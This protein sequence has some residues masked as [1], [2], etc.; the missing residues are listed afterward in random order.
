VYVVVKSVN[1]SPLGVTL[2][3]AKGAR[4]AADYVIVTVPLGVL[5]AGSIS[6]SPPLPTAKRT[7]INTMV[8]AGG[9]VNKSIKGKR[10]RDWAWL[11]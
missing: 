4:I 9:W 11:G 10:T 8:R 7:A 2:T 3:T 5:K 1:Q 6:F